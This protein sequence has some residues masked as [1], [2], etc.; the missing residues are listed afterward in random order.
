MSRPSSPRKDDPGNSRDAAQFPLPRA[1]PSK[2]MLLND[3][4]SGEQDLAGH[5]S[6]P[7]APNQGEISSKADSLLPLDAPHTPA[8]SRR[9]GRK[10]LR[11]PPDV[12]VITTVPQSAFTLLLASHARFPLNP[13]V[14]HHSDLSNNLFVQA[15]MATWTAPANDTAK[16]YTLPTTSLASS[17]EPAEVDQLDSAPMPGASV[18][19][20]P[21]PRAFDKIL[22]HQAYKARIQAR[23][24]FVTNFHNNALSN[25]IFLAALSATRATA[26]QD[27]TLS[28]TGMISLSS[29]DEPAQKHVLPSSGSVESTQD[30][31]ATP[32][33]RTPRKRLPTSEPK[34]DLSPVSTEAASP[35]KKATFVISRDGP[36]LT[37]LE[38]RLLLTF[39]DHASPTKVCSSHTTELA[40][41]APTSEDSEFI[42]LKP[43]ATAGPEQSRL[44]PSPDT[45]LFEQT[46]NGGVN[47]APVLARGPSSRNDDSTAITDELAIANFAASTTN[48]DSEYME[49]KGVGCTVFAASPTRADV[50]RL[51]RAEA[52][53]ARVTSTVADAALGNGQRPRLQTTHSNH[54][55]NWIYKSTSL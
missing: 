6:T 4:E 32:P 9:S 13:S 39:Y 15:G 22:R 1:F 12:P 27:T 51:I 48:S 46:T 16:N 7:S 29:S 31:G 42:H 30:D 52:E 23:R 2:Y 8:R 36:Q 25:K 10:S 19:T 21:E 40:K 54:S 14:F 47:D 35:N 44:L 17:D 41:T 37:F 18:E 55:R 33:T 53:T 38:I 45:I 3:D 43:T 28:T 49:R 24:Q 34:Q 20:V 5:F 26:T 11:T 50:Q